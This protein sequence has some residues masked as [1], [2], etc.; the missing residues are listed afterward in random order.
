MDHCPFENAAEST[1][2]VTQSRLHGSDLATGDGRD[3]LV[4]HVLQKPEHQDLPMLQG[5][6]VQRRMNALPIL[7]GKVRLLGAWVDYLVGLLHRAEGQSSFTQHAVGLAL[8]DPVQ[9]GGERPRVS[10]IPN[11]AKHRKPDFLQ[12]I[13]DAIP[14]AER[15][16]EIVAQPRAVALDQLCEGSFIARLAAQDQ[17]LL[18]ES[19][20]QIGH[21]QA[22]GV[23]AS[24][25]TIRMRRPPEMFKTVPESDA[26]AVV[27]SRQNPA[28]S[29]ASYSRLGF[30]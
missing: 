8:S 18:R 26:M 23:R 17:D 28:A 19:L 5:E 20:L 15:F 12:G 29:F 14:W 13:F 2:G 1:L 25:P 4:R 16:L 7:R 10:Q 24:P 21:R 6:F 30:A 11:L 22:H 3:V 9:P 27:A